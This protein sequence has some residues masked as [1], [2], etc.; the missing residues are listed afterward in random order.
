MKKKE[1]KTKIKK[2]SINFFDALAKSPIFKLFKNMFDN[3]GQKKIKKIEV[4]RKKTTRK[5]ARDANKPP[6]E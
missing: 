6:E 1:K 2:P 4:V 5:E 3:D